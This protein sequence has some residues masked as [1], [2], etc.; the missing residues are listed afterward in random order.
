MIKAED[1]QVGSVLRLKSAKYYMEPVEVIDVVPRARTTGGFGVTHVQ[2]V[3]PPVMDFSYRV[4]LL[5]D[6]T[7]VLVRAEY[8]HATENTDV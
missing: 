1:I 5:S 6:G 3:Q 4:R 2:V 7:E 8:L